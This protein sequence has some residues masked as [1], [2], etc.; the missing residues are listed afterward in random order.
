MRRSVFVVALAWVL[1]CLLA[2]GC[3]VTDNEP[4][5]RVHY[6]DDM[7]DVEIVQIFSVN[8][9]AWVPAS[10][11][12]GY[13]WEDNRR[14][15]WYV[16]DREVRVE[17]LFPDAQPG[18]GQGFLPVLEINFG[19]AQYP[20][21]GYDP[22]GQWSGLMKLITDAGSD[23]SDMSYLEIWLRRKQG[24]G[25]RMHIDLG[26]VSENYY[27]PWAADSLHTEDKNGDGNLGDQENTGLDGVFTGHPGDDPYDDWAFSEGDY[28]R[29]NG[30]ELN[31]RTVPD[32]EDL[33]GDG[34][35]D[36]D[37]IHFSLSFDLDDPAYIV[38]EVDEWRLHRI[39]LE[40]AVENGGSPIWESI[41]YMRFFFTETDSPAVYQIAYFE[42][43]GSTWENEGVREYWEM[44]PTAQP[45]GEVFQI[46][47]KNTRDDPDYFP[48]YDPGTDAQGYMKREQSMMLSFR[49]EAAWHCGAAH[50]WLDNTEDLSLYEALSFY[51]HGDDIA[52][53]VDLR[54]FVRLGT[55]SLNFYEYG[56]RVLSGWNRPAVGFDELRTVETYTAQERTI[57]GN[58]VSVRMGETA[59]G[60]IR[61]CGE[62]DLAEISWIGAGLVLGAGPAPG[63][64]PTEVWLDDLCVTGFK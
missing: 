34:R 55:D 2:G 33:D 29:I 50:R 60:W 56:T 62:P 20:G 11:P 30:T 14:I 63:P 46:G 43:A 59:G 32:T 41:R 24:S 27:N 3:G 25:G 49:A 23:Y 10:V 31:P 15:G 19:D 9:E 36:P 22:E 16:K 21:K 28:S 7:E 54:I 8:R 52:P 42:L 38:R 53:S 13:R 45:T 64:T 6:L 48:P 44:S 17:D 18:P 12:A 39:P 1:L 26:E 35:L 5:R 47:A 40:D 51:V 58:T 4:C 61:I 37:D 57:Y